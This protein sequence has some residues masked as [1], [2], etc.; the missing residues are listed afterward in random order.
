MKCRAFMCLSVVLLPVLAWSPAWA[1]DSGRDNPVTALA[2]SLSITQML[3]DDGWTQTVRE[4]APDLFSGGPT[5]PLSFTYHHQIMRTEE[6]HHRWELATGSSTFNQSLRLGQPMPAFNGYG[7]V[8]Y[9]YTGLAG[10]KIR[11]VVRLTADINQGFGAP[12]GLGGGL[13]PAMGFGVSAQA[14]MEFLLYRNFGLGITGGLQYSYQPLMQ[15][16]NPYM[17]T[18][19]PTVHPRERL[20]RSPLGRRKGDGQVPQAGSSRQ[21]RGMD[22]GLLLES[23]ASGLYFFVD[24]E[25]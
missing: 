5:A 11:P 4:P 24:D 17:P 21:K 14:G 13:K 1:D 8:T 18:L 6:D 3:M 16:Q 7:M 19:S 25:D 9:R 12:M 20:Q 23:L 22:W 2:E 10:G 15:R